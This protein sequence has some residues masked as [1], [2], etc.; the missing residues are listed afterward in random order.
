VVSLNEL[1]TELRKMLV[2]L[3][4]EDVRQT[5][6]RPDLAAAVDPGQFSR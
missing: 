6:R 2:R 4:G 5:L 3:L 1:L